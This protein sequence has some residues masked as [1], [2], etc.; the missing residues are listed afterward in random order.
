MEIK[1]ILDGQLDLQFLT[2][3]LGD[4]LEAIGW[5]VPLRFL[6]YPELD[7][8]LLVLYESSAVS[9]SPEAHAAF[10]SSLARITPVLGKSA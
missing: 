7:K 5:V 4:P 1:E 8:R 9:P 3:T 10:D 6:A 2:V